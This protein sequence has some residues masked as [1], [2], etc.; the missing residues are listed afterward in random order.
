MTRFIH[1]RQIEF[2]IS[3]GILKLSREC[4]NLHYFGDFHHWG[5]GFLDVDICEHEGVKLVVVE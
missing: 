2:I 4:I 5:L 3:F 1:I